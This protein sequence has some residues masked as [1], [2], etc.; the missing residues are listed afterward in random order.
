MCY[1][2]MPASHK[3]PMLCKLLKTLD[4]IPTKT[5][6]YVSTCAAVDYLQHVLPSVVKETVGDVSLIPLHGKHPPA[7]RHK[8][9]TKFS[10]A[11]SPSILLTTD[12]AA[13]GLDIPELDLVVQIDAPSD[14]K[15]FLHRCGRA[16]RAG[17]KGLAVVFLHSGRE[18]EYVQLLDVRKT[19]VTPLELPGL[20]VGPEDAKEVVDRIRAIAR[21]DRALH[22]KAQ[23]GFV[24]WV[25]SYSK[26]QAGSIFRITDLDW[27]D[28][29]SAWGL[30]RMP[31]MPE[32]KN[33]EGD[34]DLGLG[35]D[36]KR[37]AYR[38]RLREKLRQE[39]LHEESMHPN[40]VARVEPQNK[41]SWSDKLDR[42][43]ETARQREK[44]QKKRAREKWDQMTSTEREEQ[45]ELE[46][47]IEQVKS[48]AINDQEF[49]G[50][51]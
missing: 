26:H 48:N 16:G 50:F 25:R 18:E 2:T 12:V 41:R 38:D 7:V 33:W 9:F 31:K 30:L 43:D 35:V 15:V 14:P 47:M 29:G 23:R 28:L 8:N 17:R 10:D 34:R 51:D 27:S 36:F 13:R 49:Q 11:T 20:Y 42:K 37:Y 32:L 44:R 45:I 4:P 3:I 46:R 40:S 24:S 19:P 6:V 21:E 1:L 5:I 22:D 39:A